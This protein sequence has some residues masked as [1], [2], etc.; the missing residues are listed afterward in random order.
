MHEEG[1]WA[2]KCYVCLLC[3]TVRQDQ[4]EDRWCIGC[5]HRFDS[6][7]TVDMVGSHILQCELARE[8][9]QKFANYDLLCT[10]LRTQHD[11]KNSD[12]Q[13]SARSFPVESNWPGECGFCGAKVAQWEGRADHIEA[14]FLRGDKASEVPLQLFNVENNNL[15]GMAKHGALMRFNP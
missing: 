3:A 5:S 6:Y 1:H 11:I 14:H 9:S 2:P 10:H 15:Q 12:L 13:S 4:T 7:F 8:R